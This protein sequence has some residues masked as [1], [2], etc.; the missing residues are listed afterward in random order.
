MEKHL[1]NSILLEISHKCVYVVQT[2]STDKS[3]GIININTDKLYA[4]R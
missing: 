2:I 4:C 3:I 1:Q